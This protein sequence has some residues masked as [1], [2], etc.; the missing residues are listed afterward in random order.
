MKFSRAIENVIIFS[1]VIVN[2]TITRLKKKPKNRLLLIKTDVIGDYI[3]FRNC[4]AFLK[5]SDAFKDAEITMLGN[6]MWKDLAITLD[7]QYINK[8]IWIN[9]KAYTGFAYKAKLLWALSKQRFNTVALFHYSRTLFTDILAFTVNAPVKYAIDNDFSLI[10]PALRKWTDKIYS[11]HVHI[12]DAGYNEVMN[13]RY[14]AQ[15]LAGIN[16]PVTYRKPLID[17]T[18]NININATFNIPS[19]YIVLATGAGSMQRKMEDDKWLTIIG[20]LLKQD[21]FLCFTGTAADAYM[22][23]LAKAHYSKAINK[24]IDVTG[25]T[26]LP[27]LLYLLNNA[28]FVLCHDSSTYHA[29][30]AL[31]KKTICFA[32]GGHF[33]RWVNY[34]DDD[35]IKTVYMPMPCYNCNW[36]CVYNIKKGEVYPCIKAIPLQNALLAVQQM[37]ACSKNI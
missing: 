26:S 36:H 4:I 31:Q 28:Q 20:E 35:S 29:S 14:F 22:V 18:G 5:Q 15:T 7:E 34:E 32:G 37:L 10:T 27:Q 33:T 24:I 17:L 3:A 9:Q 12:P 13:N 8:F 2:K 21:Y 16:K 30:V 23:E 11:N 25:K 19:K 6:E 1:R